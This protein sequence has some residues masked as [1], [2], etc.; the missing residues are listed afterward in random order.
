[1]TFGDLSRRLQEST[2]NLGAFVTAILN[3]YVDPSNYLVLA[4]YLEEDHDDPLAEMLR[5]VVY[6]HDDNIPSEQREKMAAKFREI[7]L[8]LNAQAEQDHIHY[9]GNRTIRY[10]LPPRQK[11][12]EPVPQ[13]LQIRSG[14]LWLGETEVNP[15]TLPVPVQR[16]IITHM[17]H[18]ALVDPAPDSKVMGG[19][20]RQEPSHFAS[21]NFNLAIIR[22]LQYLGR[23]V[24]H[25]GETEQWDWRVTMHLDV[26]LKNLLHLGSVAKGLPLEPETRRW[27]A[28]I[29]EQV[30]E[31][32]LRRRD[33]G[34][35]DNLERAFTGLGWSGES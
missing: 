23:W 15:Q 4:D 29:W 19:A 12:G 5:L 28:S 26:P 18:N 24:D 35:V 14:R 7:Y 30:R 33:P 10:H 6:I 17:A 2:E 9:V 34:F 22:N 3:N 25:A 20:D 13:N 31:L 8:N 11:G 27:I 32:N 16:A 1:M 21:R